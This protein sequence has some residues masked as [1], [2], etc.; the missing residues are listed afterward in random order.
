MRRQLAMGC[1]IMTAAALLS[2]L[3]ATGLFGRPQ[4]EAILAYS[5]GESRFDPCARSR[6]GEGLIGVAGTLR[7]LLHREVGTAGCVSPEAQVAF[8]AR[9]WPALYP[10]C[11]AR[12]D[13]GDLGAFRR[14]WGRGHRR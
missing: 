2:L 10:E 11:A 3:L 4:A 1:A 6:M 13:A 12:F 8:L 7:R 5:W 14:C 9:H